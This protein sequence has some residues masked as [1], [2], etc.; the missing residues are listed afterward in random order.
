MPQRVLPDRACKNAVY[1]LQETGSLEQDETSPPSYRAAL[2]SE[3]RLDW[4][5]AMQEE[6]TTL[7]EERGCWKF[8]P[9]L[10]GHQRILRCHF[11]FK[12]KTK[13]GKVVRYKARLVIY[14]SGQVQSINYSETFA[15]VVKYASFRLYCAVC[16]V[17]HMQ[18]H[19]LDVKNVFI[20]ANLVF[21]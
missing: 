16:C 21:C 18:I 12:K 5:R 19:Q 6:I 7:Q 17:H 2:A 3:E 15:P 1:I 14:G 4:K 11:V 13:H 20:Y 9:Y 10:R 8:V